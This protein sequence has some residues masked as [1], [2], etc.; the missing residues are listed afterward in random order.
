MNIH[1]SKSDIW[2]WGA[3]ETG[4]AAD[5]DAY[6]GGGS[7]SRMNRCFRAETGSAWALE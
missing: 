4:S 6:C 2:M 3:T 5:M 7:K 1:R